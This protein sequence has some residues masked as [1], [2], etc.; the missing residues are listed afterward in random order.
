MARCM[1]DALVAALPR[2]AAPRRLWLEVRASNQ[3]ARGRLRAATASTQVGLRRATT[4][5][6]AGSAKTP[7]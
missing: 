2:R 5:R 3:R 6:R 7:S 1:L 4:R